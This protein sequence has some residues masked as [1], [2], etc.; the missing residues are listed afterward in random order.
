MVGS[1][2]TFGFISEVV[3][4]TLPLERRVSAAL[5]FFASLP[6]AAAAVPCSPPRAPRPSS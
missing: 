1:E 4:D 5:L 2:G 3:F 6:A